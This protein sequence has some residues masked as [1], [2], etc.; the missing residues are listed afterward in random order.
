MVDKALQN[1]VLRDIALLSSVGVYKWTIETQIEYYQNTG[2]S[3]VN[4]CFDWKSIKK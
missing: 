3:N 4:N 1:A 2:V